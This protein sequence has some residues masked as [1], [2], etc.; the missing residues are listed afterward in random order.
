MN[1]NEDTIA[2]VATPVG[3]GG[4]GIIR[5]SGNKAKAVAEKIAR[6]TP[7]PRYA[8]YS[9]FVDENN[10]KIDEG[11]VIYFISPHSY[12]GEDIV[13]FQCHGG[14]VVLNRLMQEILKDSSIRQASP[15]EFTKRAF[16]NGK[17]DLTQAE[18]IQDLINATSIQASKSAINSLSGAFSNKIN[19]LLEILIKL[20]TFV[21]ASIDFPDESIDFVN[22]GNVMNELHVLKNQIEEIKNTAKQGILLTEGV[23]IV[24]A[25]RPNAGK[26]SLL[27]ELLGVERAIVTDI[28]GTTRDTIKETINI[29]GLPV[30]I[31]DTAGLRK[32]TD[33]TVE[34]IG[35]N[36]SWNEIHRA[37]RILFL[38]DI[39]DNDNKEQIN[40]FKEI[41][42]N[43]EN[44][45]PCTILFNKIDKNPDFKVPEELK[46]FSFLKI[47]VK[48][49]SGISELKEHIKYFAGYTNSTEGIFSA[50]RRHLIAIDKVLNSLNNAENN[51][52]NNENLEIAAEDLRIAQNNLNEI[53]GK[54]TADDLLGSIFNTFCV[55][56]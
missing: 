36:R 26:S 2:A 50:R 18:A 55:G 31:I 23:N 10:N 29:D 11:L 45:T 47:S 20:R 4:V 14:P 17:I 48:E 8:H 30:H 22:E 3:H 9:D 7:S 33:N 53:T 24:I 43:T 56:K 19:E 42:K 12:T 37:S 40:L 5:I 28:A 52:I 35:I 39:S 21:E 1:F 51:I 6:I 13:E 15:G 32:N 54:Y 27:N 38:F 46:T 25:G 44:N 41:I 16:L 34:K 49:K